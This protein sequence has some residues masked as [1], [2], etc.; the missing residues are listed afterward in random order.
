MLAVLATGQKTAVK[1][2]S[3]RLGAVLML[4]ASLHLCRTND[5]AG[6]QEGSHLQRANP[7]G[8]LSK[9]F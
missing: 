8:E 6:G 9:S 1:T 7:T 4:I 3:A 5:A 2:S